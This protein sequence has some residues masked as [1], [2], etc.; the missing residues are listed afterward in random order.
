MPFTQISEFHVSTLLTQF[1]VIDCLHDS[2]GSDEIQ[3]RTVCYKQAGITKF[4]DH[5]WNAI[6]GIEDCLKCILFKN[7][8]FTSGTIQLFNDLRMTF[9]FCHAL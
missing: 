8:L 6:G 9:R 3:A 5:T 2:I 1:A 7:S 4:V